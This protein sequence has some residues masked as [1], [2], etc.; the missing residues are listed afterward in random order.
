MLRHLRTAALVAAMSTVATSAQAEIIDR[1]LVQVNEGIVT[2]SDLTRYLPI[3]TEVFALPPTAFGTRE[4]C[5][6]TVEGFVDYLIES[7]ILLADATT[8][9]LGVSSTEIERYIGQQH[10]QMNMSREQFEIELER[11]GIVFADFRDFIEMNLT[12]MR[13]MQLDV[14]ARVSITDAAVDRALEEQ[15]PDGLEEV[16]ISTHHIF[17]QIAADS[18]AAEAAAEAEIQARAARLAAGESFESVASDNDDGTAARGG[19]LGRI[20]VLSL[21]AAYSEAA[22][23]LEIGEVSDPVRSSFGYHII[24]LDDLERSPVTDAQDIRDRVFFDLH[25]ERAAEEQDLY[26]ERVRNEAFVERLVDDYS[27]YCGVL[28]E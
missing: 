12:R 4:A 24:R 26:L 6:N 8:R 10:Q 28:G 18:P 16:H 25:Q 23:A 15:Y 14:G 7:Q 27:W 13:M 9:E 1:V 17:V 2:Q 19:R 20:S 22:V 3:Y 5:E 21:D 11:S